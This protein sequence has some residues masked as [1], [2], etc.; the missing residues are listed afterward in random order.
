[1]SLRRLGTDWLDL[2]VLH[3]PDPFTPLDE[4]LRACE[5]L[6]RSGKVRYVGYSNWPAWRAAQAVTAQAE[7]RWTRFCCA[8]MYYSLVGRDVE[9]DTV[10]L[11]LS[12][13]A[14]V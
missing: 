5:D 8:Q 4:T 6:V 14:G 3:K 11:A 7:R 2:F 12:A 13:G 9:R 1:G 10:P